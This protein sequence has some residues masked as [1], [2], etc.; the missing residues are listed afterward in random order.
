MCA[1]ALIWARVKKVVFGAGDPKAGALGSVL[2]LQQEANF[3]HKLEVKAGVLAEPSLTL[4]RDF[5]SRRRH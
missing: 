3:N 1:G 2:S 5:F 4:L